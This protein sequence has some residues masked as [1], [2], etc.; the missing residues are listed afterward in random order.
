VFLLVVL[1]IAMPAGPAGARPVPGGARVVTEEAPCAASEAGDVAKTSPGLARL[2]GMVCVKAPGD[3]VLRWR[4][5]D[6]STHRLVGAVDRLYQAYFRR[7][8]D[9]SEFAYWINLRVDGM[10]LA[11][12]SENFAAGSEFRFS[13]RTRTLNAI[14]NGAFVDAVYD[15]VLQ[16]PPDPDGKTHWL[17]LL[18]RAEITRPQLMAVFAQSPEFRARTGTI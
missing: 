6:S 5:L 15:R 14:F 2:S 3:P 16:R 17:D 11:A 12:I 7:L 9:G 13:F 4:A 18:N 1:S 8:P 10:P